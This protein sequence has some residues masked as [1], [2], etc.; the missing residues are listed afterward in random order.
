LIHGCSP[1]DEESNSCAL[2][3]TDEERSRGPAAPVAC[4]RPPR[5]RRT[6]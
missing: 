4:V 2:E 5:W 1:R 6:R 3:T